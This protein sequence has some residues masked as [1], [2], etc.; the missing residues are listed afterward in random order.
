M[1][2]LG[3]PMEAVLKNHHKVR[4]TLAFYHLQEQT[5]HFTDWAQYDTNGVI[6]KAGNFVIVNRTAWFQLYDEE[7]IEYGKDKDR[8]ETGISE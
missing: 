1:D 3:K 5:I 4:G 6:V 8:P 7:G 2:Y